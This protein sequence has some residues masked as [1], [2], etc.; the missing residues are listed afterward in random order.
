MIHY[1]CLI[2]LEN[3]NPFINIFNINIT[4]LLTCFIPILWFIFLN[5]CFGWKLFKA[6]YINTDEVN[7]SL[8]NYKWY[9]IYAAFKFSFYIRVMIQILM[10]VVLISHP[11]CKLLIIA[12]ISCHSN[13]NFVYSH[14]WKYYIGW[15]VL[16]HIHITTD[17]RSLCD[18]CLGT[19]YKVWQ[20]IT[21][22]TFQCWVLQWCH[23][24]QE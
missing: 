13:S 16:I 15:R 8:I 20:I 12:T 2:G 5:I 9:K 24:R 3:G 21:N 10:T 22:T 18:H 7:N 17:I 6:G 4:L 11:L 19:L 14:W 1:T 23:I